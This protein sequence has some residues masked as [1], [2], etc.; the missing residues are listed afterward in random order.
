MKKT[1]ALTALLLVCVA[2]FAQGTIKVEAP[3]LVAVDEQFNV[4]FIVEGENAPNDFQWSPTDDFQLTWGPQRGTSTSISIVNGKRTKSAQSSYTYVLTPK[5]AGSF[6]LPPA[7]ATLKGEK[8]VSR[9]VTIEVVSN[10]AAASS[11]SG[12]GSSLSSGSSGA[13]TAAS[14]EVPSEDIFMRMTLSKSKAVVGEP[15]SVSLKLYQRVNIAGFEDARF[16]TFN[17]FW[18]QEVQA[19]TNIEFHRESVGDMI[20][21]AAV[22]RSYVI[23]PQQSG[24]LTIDPSELVCLVN[25]R[26][27]NSSMG[28]IFDSFFQDDYRTVPKRVSTPSYTVKVSPLPAGAPASFCG[29][30]G[31]FDVKASLSRDSL[32]AHDAASLKIT[33]SGKGNVSLLE[34]PKVN[35]PPDFEVYD[36][37]TTENTDKASGR[38]GGSKTFEYPFIPRSHGDFTI[39][40]IEYSYFDISARKYVTKTAPEMHIAVSRSAESEQAASSGQIATGVARKDVRNLDS[41]IRYIRSASGSLRPRGS[42]FVFSGG[43]WALLAALIAAGFVIWAVLKK[44]AALKA[45]VVGTKNRAANKMA[46]RRL[47]NAGDFLS[48]GLYTAFYEELH[49]A[50]LGY[51]GDKLNIDIADMSKENISSRLVEAGV[52]EAVAGDFCGL[53]DD[54]E[55]ARYSPAGD[56]GAMNEHYEKAVSVISAIDSSIKGRPAASVAKKVLPMLLLLLALPLGAAEWED[57]VQAYSDGNYAEAAAH[58]S[59]IEAQGLESAD[60]YYNLGNAYF[61]SDDY[62]RAILYYERALKLSPSDKDIR[63]NLE[64]ARSFCQDRIE[65]IPEILIEQIGHKMCRVLPGNVWCVLFFIFFAFAVCCALLYLLGRQTSRRKLG[66]FAGIIMLLCALL[67]LDF[68]Q[69]QRSEYMDRSQAI[70]MPPVNSVKSTPAA[71]GGKD[72]FVLHEGTKVKILEEVGSWCNVEL[73]DGRQGWMKTEALERI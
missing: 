7:T 33:V 38:T 68:A 9:T 56:N 73:S 43:F 19:P 63:H 27:H 60:L 66:F 45:D 4:T 71:S 8:L 11:G 1:A 58:W 10:S 36:V 55:M 50:I 13:Q 51:V 3:N 65:E 2:L 35:F 48:K 23:I 5:K 17:G 67:S 64:F 44:N 20:Y 62:A 59:A 26:T 29:G 49:K 46:R 28:S 69:W 30:V 57:G 15:I 12:G 21:N 34:A 72:L 25:V 32:Q 6:T 61:K 18:S 31:S 70:V 42:M 53:L 37:K 39:G 54:C 40:P 14:G 16:P 47:A 22:L 41:D 52:P 24:E